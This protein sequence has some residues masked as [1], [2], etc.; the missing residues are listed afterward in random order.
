MRVRKRTISTA[1]SSNQDVET[2]DCCSASSSTASVDV[3]PT[4]ED[5][6]GIIDTASSVAPTDSSSYEPKAKKSRINVVENE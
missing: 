2:T 3:T 6:I 1:N 5:A 4:D